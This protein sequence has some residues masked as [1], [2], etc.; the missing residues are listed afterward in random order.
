MIMA[1]PNDLENVMNECRSESK[2]HDVAVART[3]L[4][5]HVQISEDDVKSISTAVSMQLVHGLLAIYHSGDLTV[6][7][8]L[9][10]G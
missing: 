3:N 5:R 10:D 6:A 1:G 2:A 7:C 8:S 9:Q 4:V